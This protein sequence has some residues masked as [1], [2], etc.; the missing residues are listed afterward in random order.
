MF[1]K[2]LRRVIRLKGVLLGEPTASFTFC[3]VW[4]FLNPLQLMGLPSDRCAVGAVLPQKE[5]ATLW[6][7]ILSKF[8]LLLE[9]LLDALSGHQDPGLR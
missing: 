1:N 4:N 6:S 9:G 7:L 8:F 2:P 3:V 5:S